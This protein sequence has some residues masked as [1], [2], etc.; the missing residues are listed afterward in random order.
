MLLQKEL[1]LPVT[2]LFLLSSC[3]DSALAAIPCVVQTDFADCAEYSFS[4][5]NVVGF[6]ASITYVDLDK[7]ARQDT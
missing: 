7:G 6:T 4:K 2:F 1:I 3:F 5:L